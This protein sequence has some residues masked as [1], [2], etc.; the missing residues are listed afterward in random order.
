MVISR[1]GIDVVDLKTLRTGAV[2]G[3]HYE[4]VGTFGT[5]TG[6]MYSMVT[7]APINLRLDDLIDSSTVTGSVPFNS[8]VIRYTEPSPFNQWDRAKLFIFCSK[9]KW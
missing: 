7:A 3:Q 1:V 6:Q 4:L 2:E 9:F 5:S 8:P